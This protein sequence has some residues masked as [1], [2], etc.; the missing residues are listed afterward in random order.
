MSDEA[1]PQGN[2][3]SQSE[4]ADHGT[5]RAKSASHGDR[6][7]LKDVL[8]TDELHARPDR[9]ANLAEES[10]C[11]RSLAWVMANSPEALVD[12]VLQTALRLC[13][14]GTAGL[15]VLDRTS[16]HEEVFRWTNLAGRLAGHV[17]ETTPR[18]FSPCGVTADAGSPQL[19]AHPG[20]Y[21]TY[22]SENTSIPI[23]EGLVIPVRL[24]NEIPATIWILSHKDGAYFDA[25]DVR[26]MAGLA[27]FTSCAL[28]LTRSAAA[29]KK[30]LHEGEGELAAHKATE[31]NL[32]ETQSGLEFVIDART[33]QLQQLSARLITLQD[34]ERRRIARELHDSAGQYLAAIQMNLSATLREDRALSPAQVSR[35]SDSLQIVER[36]TSEIRTI[37]YLLH[38]PLLDEMGLSSAISWYAEGFAERSGI[39][40]D[41]DIPKNLGRL[42]GAIETAL[43]RVVQQSLAN[44]HRHS[45]SHIA[46]IRIALDAERVEMEVCDHGRGIPAEILKG[47]A[48]ATRLPGV[49]LAGMRERVLAM[50]GKFNIKSG[51]AGTTIGVSLPVQEI[52]AP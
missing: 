39:H 22:L 21:F 23:V 18:N 20:R 46:K 4:H 6:V 41:L 1:R 8:I 35:I 32:R 19:F 43:F 45:G 24:G 40:V 28:R 27:E 11:L 44:I 52:S 51:P 31:A 16:T 10:D 26:I 34:D 42:P 29:A 9:R 17:G 38:P 33:S 50:A 3:P 30:A 15:S 47:F 14:A 2:H 5:L 12:T 49:G 37:S 48:S 36:C 25:E 13:N 7:E